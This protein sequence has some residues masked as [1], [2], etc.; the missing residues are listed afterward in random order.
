MNFFLR[1][2]LIGILSYFF[3]M[4][5]PWWIVVVIGF[6]GGILIPGGSLR[7][8]VS[9]FLGVGIV[10]MGYAWKLDSENESSFSNIILGLFPINDSIVLIVLEVYILNV[11]GFMP[12]L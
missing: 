8:F 5:T 10:W 3:S 9:G 7:V 4:F 11:F 6:T 2:I 12:K 1:L